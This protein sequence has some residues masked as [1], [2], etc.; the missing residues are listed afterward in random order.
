MLGEA[1]THTNPADIDQKIKMTVRFDGSVFEPQFAI[2]LIPI[3]K[4]TLSK[5]QLFLQKA[6][7]TWLPWILRV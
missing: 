7:E 4:K 1:L 2:T 6:W 3:S 5:F